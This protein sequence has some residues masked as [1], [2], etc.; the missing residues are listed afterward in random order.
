[1]AGV[2]LQIYDLATGA[3]NAARG[4][5]VASQAV[6]RHIL[7]TIV[8]GVSPTAKAVPL[9]VAEDGTLA[10]SSTIAGIDPTVTIP[11]TFTDAVI[12]VRGPA[13][14]GIACIAV[15]AV[16]GS[17]NIAGDAAVGAAVTAQRIIRLYADGSDIYYGWSADGVP[18][19]DPAAV[20]GN[21]RCSVI[22]AGQYRDERPPTVGGVLQGF[23]HYKTPTNMTGTLRVYA[24]STV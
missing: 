13:L 11:V 18:V 4:G 7:N 1:M 17:Y 14:G 10:S 20:A 24:S 16:A 6:V 19:I 22:P 12:G 15:T 2:S 9:K 23:I 8:M 21:T 5:L 3:W